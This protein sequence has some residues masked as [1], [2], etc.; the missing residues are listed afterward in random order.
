M[1]TAC[2][3]SELLSLKTAALHISSG[4]PYVKFDGKGK[5]Q[6]IVP[7][8]DDMAQALNQYLELFHG[9]DSVPT[10]WLFYTI[11]DGLP[12]PMK[13][14]TFQTLLSKYSAT[15]RTQDPSFPDRVHPHMLRRTRA[16]QLYR[17][18]LTFEMVSGI[19][20]HEQE[21]TTKIYATPSL[22]QLRTVMQEGQLRDMM[23]RHDGRSKRMC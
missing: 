23:S 15:A 7:I 12:T 17:D 21:E 2:R 14:R 6:R 20:G 19:L 4:T 13:P 11:H 1:S 5:K 18:G 10:D 8:T 3:V 16:T 9:N 22:E